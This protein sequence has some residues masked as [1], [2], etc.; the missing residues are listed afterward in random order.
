MGHIRNMASVIGIITCVCLSLGFAKGSVLVLHTSPSEVKDGLTDTL[1]LRC[2]VNDTSTSPAAIV[3]RRDLDTDMTSSTA[4]DVQEVTSMVMTLN[5]K[6]IASVSRKQGAS[7]MGG[8]GNVQVA[9]AVDLSPGERSFLEV[10]I[11]NPTKDQ[12]GEFMCEASAVGGAGHGVV[13]K[14]SVEVGITP[15]TMADLISYVHGLKADRDAANQKIAFLEKERDATNLRLQELEHTETGRIFCGN[16]QKWTGRHTWG[17]IPTR[18]VDFR[19][20]FKTPY[21]TPPTIKLGTVGID[22]MTGHDTR[23]VV[24]VVSVDTAGF[25]ARC[26]TWADS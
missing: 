19:Q 12:V 20:Q 15:P 2:D 9:G 21:K 24:T 6:D 1:T 13:L 17:S 4:V 22:A 18:D 14:D 16:S 7:V 26:H 10:T 25:T 23:Y 3:G 5:G 11:Q 8:S